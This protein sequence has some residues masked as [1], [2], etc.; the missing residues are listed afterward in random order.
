MGYLI[1]CGVIFL[2]IVGAVFLVH[3]LAKHAPIIDPYDDP[4]DYW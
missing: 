3:W 4:D 1:T 2:G